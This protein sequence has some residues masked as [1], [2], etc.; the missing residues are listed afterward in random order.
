M[1]AQDKLQLLR[2]IEEAEPSNRRHANA[3]AWG[4]V[5]LAAALMALLIGLSSR[6][7]IEI[8]KQVDAKQ[9]ELDG[10][11]EALAAK[12]REIQEL[13]NV[14]QAKNAQVLALQGILN[15]LPDLQRSALVDRALTQRPET[16]RVVPRIYLQVVDPTDRTFGNAIRRALE[17]ASYLVLGL[18]VVP[19]ATGLRVTDVRFYRK[20][21]EPEAERILAVLKAAGEGNARINYL[22]GFEDSPKVRPNHFEVWLAKRTAPPP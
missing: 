3:I 1:D 2:A 16:A 8:R 7:L 17:D 20:V 4:S 22:R 11:V 21:E 9:R 13:E 12:Q 6:Q 18:Q 19:Q 10:Q 5:V 15:T 14:R